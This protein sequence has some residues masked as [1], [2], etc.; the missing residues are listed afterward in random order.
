MAWTDRDGK[1]VEAPEP[2][3]AGS[4]YTEIGD[5]QGAAY[6][7]NAFALGTEQEVAFLWDALGLRPGEV[8]V[9]VGCGTGR[10]AR[11][12]A[13]RGVRAIGVDISQGLLAAA[14]AHR[15]TAVFL[16]ADA[17]A[18]PLP[19]ACAD[20]VICL[21]QGGFGITPGGDAA[22]LAEIARVLRPGGRL[23]L[24]AFSLAF[25][26]RWLAPEDAIDLDRGLVHTPADVRGADGES[27]RYDLWTSCYTVAELRHLLAAASFDDVRLSGVEPG[28]YRHD[29][30]GIAD[31]ELLAI[32]RRA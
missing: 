12:L 1:P 5:F 15:T 2:P 16:R 32:A 24:T 21:C 11:A 8:L 4:Y 29:P 23:A 28:A 31:P 14:A 20:V 13:Q 19:D 7:R 3:A 17:R 26:T 9:D 18:I 22:V 6:E 25:A 30:P 10:H 27:R